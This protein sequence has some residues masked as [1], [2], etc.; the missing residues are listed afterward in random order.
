MKAKILAVAL[1]IGFTGAASAQKLDSKGF[2]AFGNFGTITGDY[3]DTPNSGSWRG[4]GKTS[5][6]SWNVGLGYDFNEHFAVEGSY[7]SLFKSE[8]NENSSWSNGS[9]TYISKTNLTGLQVAFLG[10]IAPS[11]NV[12]LFAGPVWNHITL[13]GEDTT[14]N[15]GT[16][17]SNSTAQ[18]QSFNKNLT[19]VMFGA[20]FALDQ[21]TDLRVSYTKYKS[22]LLPFSDGTGNENIKLSQFLFGIGVKF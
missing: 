11:D 8:K 13:K 17:Y 14:S 3:D 1:A 5:S 15:S 2:Y 22:M 16:G 19:G 12:K 7:G 6:N 10:K 21:R 9:S 20:S 18:S 4:N